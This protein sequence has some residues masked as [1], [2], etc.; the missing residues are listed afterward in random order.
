MRAD[1]VKR[2]LDSPPEPVRESVK[3]AA[4]WYCRRLRPERKFM[5]AGREYSYFYHPYNLAWR[6][7]RSVEIPLALDRLGLYS[8]RPVLE[9]G[10][11]LAHYVP[12]EHD[13]IDKYERW[14]GVLNAD[15]TEFRTE[16]RYDLIL[17]ISTLEHV[18]ASQDPPEPRKALAAIENLTGLL[19]AGGEL[20]MTAPLG[21]NPAFDCLVQRGHIRFSELR[22]MKR[23]GRKNE[24]Q[25][26]SY[27][28]VRGRSYPGSRFRAEAIIVGT[29]RQR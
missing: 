18:G 6:N 24:W 16:K 2:L 11:V 1:A 29:V 3:R 13:V 19:A 8:G 10:N 28:E 26:A 9:V 7:E 22:A 25:E 27:D 23:S 5:F 20:W 14:P 4:V 17:S 15:A 21:L 12:V